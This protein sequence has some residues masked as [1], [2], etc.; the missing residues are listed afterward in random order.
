MSSMIFYTDNSVGI[1]TYSP[2]TKLT[3]TYA[4][5]FW[6]VSQI[7]NDY[8]AAQKVTN[9]RMRITSDGCMRITHNPVL[10]DYVFRSEYMAESFIKWAKQIDDEEYV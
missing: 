10:E 7:G 1:G 4:P 5:H 3:L 8:W 2:S 6:R 9:E